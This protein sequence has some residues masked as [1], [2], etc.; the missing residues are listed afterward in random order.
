ME[1]Q[2]EPCEKADRIA[3]AYA[4]TYDWAD[5]EA[6]KLYFR[7]ELVSDTLHEAAVLIH[8]HTMPG[9]KSWSVAVLRALY[10][11]PETRLSHAEIGAQTRVPAGNVTYHVDVLQQGGYV[12]RV[13]HE[14]DRRVSLVELTDLGRSM[15]DRLMPTRA[16][17]ISGLAQ[18]FSESERALFNQ[19]L[20]RL[21]RSIKDTVQA[22]R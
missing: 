18:E 13:P 22:C 14:T 8:N 10:M 15:C 7:L 11:A 1:Q 4:Q 5:A 2:G 16:Q 6:L 9:V 3:S 21:Q 12:R 17:F 19:F 20:D